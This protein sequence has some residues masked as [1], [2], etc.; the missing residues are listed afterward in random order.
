VSTLAQRRSSPATI[1]L[2]PH[3]WL[4]LGLV[5]IALGLAA[6][7]LLGPLATGLVD[8]RVTDTLRNQT[9]GLDAVSLVVVAPLS[10]IAAGLALRGSALG[11]ALA[12]AIGAYTS[13]MFVQYVVG[14]DYAGLPGNNERLF[15]LALFLFAAGWIVVLLAWSA[16]DVE[17]LPRSPRRE[18]LLGRVVLPLLA[19]AAFGR[20]LPALADWTSPSPEDAGYLAGPAFAWTIALLDLGVFLPAT[21]AV[22]AGLPRGAPWARKALYAV[23][24]W[25]GLVGPAVAAMAI[26]MYANGD[27]GPS[28]GQVLFMCA[29]GL[30]F[31]TLAAVVFRPL[32]PRRDPS[33]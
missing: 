8:Y 23:V 29:L 19:L 9:I 30:A 15:P 32:V 12:L 21:V 10:L 6:V 31:L 22:C 4:A 16:I 11:Q 14:P 2:E 7:A 5:A 26:A 17:R 20:Y 18:R 25:F 3:G 33:R 13:Y 27:P 1:R 28:G 24:G